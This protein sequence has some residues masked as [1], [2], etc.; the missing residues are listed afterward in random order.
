MKRH[1]APL[2]VA[3]YLCVALCIAFTG[4]LNAEGQEDAGVVTTHVLQVP[5]YHSCPVFIKNFREPPLSPVKKVSINEPGIAEVKIITPYELVVDARHTGSTMFIVWY[6]DNEVDFFEV[7][8]TSPRPVFNPRMQIIRGLNVYHYGN[9][10][11]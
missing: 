8:V 6:E 3:F 10:V 5:M 4:A 11:W 9:G 2:R 1:L 7:R